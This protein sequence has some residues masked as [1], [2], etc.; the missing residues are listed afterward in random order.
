MLKIVWWRARLMTWYLE[1]GHGPTSMLDHF[2]A[3][4]VFGSL[5]STECHPYSWIINE[6]FI[7]DTT[8]ET[9]FEIMHKYL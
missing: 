2:G 7:I 4:E 8:R 1:C 5:Q 6:R 3:V 9:P